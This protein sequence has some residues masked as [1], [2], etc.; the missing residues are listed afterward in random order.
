[1]CNAKTVKTALLHGLLPSIN[2]AN[3]RV[4]N[5]FDYGALGPVPSVHVQQ[6]L[7]CSES[8]ILYFYCF[9]NIRTLS[10]RLLFHLH[11]NIA[12]M[13]FTYFNI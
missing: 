13:H 1:M 5:A 2:C 3:G 11:G 10:F 4:G 6:G 7:V 12:F 8:Y 9:V